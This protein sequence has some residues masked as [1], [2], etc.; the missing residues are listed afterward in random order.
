MVHTFQPKH[1]WNLF[2]GHEAAVEVA[3]GDVVVTTTVDAHGV[4]ERGAT[5]A[6]PPNPLT[7]P[8]SITGARPGDCLSVRIEE[9]EPNRSSC[10]TRRYIAPHLLDP[11]LLGRHPEMNA[12]SDDRQY[13]DW[14]IDPGGDRIVARGLPPDSLPPPIPLAPMVGCIGTAPE[15]GQLLSSSTSGR[16]GGNM[17]YVGLRAGTTLYLPVFV[18]GAM[19]YLGDGHA[20]QGHGEI[21]GTGTEVSMN[22][23]LS[24]RLMK[25]YDIQWPRG[26]DD[27]FIFTLGNARPLDEALKHATSEMFRW[28]AQEYAM[29]PIRASLLLAQAVEYEVGNVFDPEYTMAC[30]LAK[31]Y[32]PSK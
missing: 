16:H 10:W 6:I 1:Y 31:R 3:S 5:V 28:L 22:V 21:G 23:R 30:R 18:E 25:R 4:D 24:L 26:E 8:F 27:R 2:G 13:V 32:L 14:E 17:D 9:L 11:E 7:G 15:G 20:T 29:T 19:L 12:S